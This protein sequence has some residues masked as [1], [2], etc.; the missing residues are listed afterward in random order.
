MGKNENQEKPDAVTSENL[1]F[2]IFI[3]TTAIGVT[4]Y[5][6]QTFATNKRVGMIEDDLHNHLKVSC[7]TALQIKVD[8]ALLKDI[9]QLQFNKR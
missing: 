4:L 2:Y 8:P 1:K 9:C 5:V 3:A 6:H 7:L